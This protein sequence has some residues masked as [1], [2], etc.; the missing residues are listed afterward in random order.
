MTVVLAIV[1]ILVLIIIV[2]IILVRIMRVVIITTVIP[3]NIDIRV[4][5]CL[6]CGLGDPL[7]IGSS[8]WV[9]GFG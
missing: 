9:W 1:V 7:V 2:V 6:V 4:P 3:V 5:R 8:V